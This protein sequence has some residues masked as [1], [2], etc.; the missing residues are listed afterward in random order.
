MNKAKILL[1]ALCCLPVLVSAQTVDTRAQFYNVR[2]EK[3]HMFLQKDSDF[4]V[5]DY[6][7]EWP[8]IISSND[9]LPLKSFISKQL[10]DTPTGDLDSATVSLYSVYGKPVKGTLKAI[11]DD[12]RFCYVTAEAKILSY[13]PDRWI[14][15][16]LERNVEPQK[17]SPYKAAKKTRV[18]V[19]DLTRQRVMLA[20]DMLRNGVLTWMMP[21]DF[22]ERLFAPLDDDMF[23]N[24]VSAKINGVWIDNGQICLLVDVLSSFA[25]K[26]YTVTMPYYD[27]RY[28]LTRDVRR[29]VE[30]DLKA[31]QPKV[32]TL[33]VVWQ[34]DTVYG[35]VDK[36]PEFRGGVDSLKRY[37]SYVAKPDVQITKPSRVFVSFIVDK[38][39]EIHQVS[40]VSPVSPVLDEHAVSVVKGMPPF[41]PGQQDGKPVCV[42]MFMPVSYKP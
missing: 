27:Y 26:T 8:D 30:K 21:D 4:N 33:P 1:P 35:K 7:V 41:T 6:D 9:V 3:A 5:I 10:F 22:Y 14:A 24:M 15:Y 17:L 20:D 32:L 29:M 28:I 18:I 38:K 12:N 2:Y 23:G 25:E 39:G 11:P 16:S 19:Y 31:S 37:L 40:V 34:G 13:M 42:R 36:M